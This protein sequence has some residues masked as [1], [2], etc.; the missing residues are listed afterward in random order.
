MGVVEKLPALISQLNKL[1][2]LDLEMTILIK[3]DIKLID[4][5]PKLCTLRIK[6]LQDSE[7]AFCVEE[8]GRVAHL[9]KCHGP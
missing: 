5:L 8:N 7:L 4:S 1:T 2:K 6:L 3:T 9:S